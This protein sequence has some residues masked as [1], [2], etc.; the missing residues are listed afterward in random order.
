[1]SGSTTQH[2]FDYIVRM[3]PPGVDVDLRFVRAI[4]GGGCCVSHAYAAAASGV[5]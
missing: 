1:M 5:D 2:F 4:E 3:A